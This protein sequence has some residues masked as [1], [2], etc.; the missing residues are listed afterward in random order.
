M[1]YIVNEE[2]QYIKITLII[3]A[4]KSSNIWNYERLC[5]RVIPFKSVW[6]QKG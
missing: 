5:V 4:L 6:G 1:L 2:K 3:H